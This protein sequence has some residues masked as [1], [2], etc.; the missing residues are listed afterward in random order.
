MRP[1]LAFIPLNAST[2]FFFSH[3]YSQLAFDKAYGG[4]WHCIVGRNFGCSVTHETKY[5]VFF[6][7]SVYVRP[8]P[9][10]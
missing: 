1:W 8:P 2:S 10:L 5:L 3:G 6:K 4:T 7:V 9:Q